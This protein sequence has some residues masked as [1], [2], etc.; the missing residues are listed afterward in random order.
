MIPDFQLIM[1]PLLESLKNG[2]EYDIK[3]IHDVLGKHFE[4]TDN[5]LDELLPD[6]EQTRFY[7]N[8]SH[9]KRHLMVAGLIEHITEDRFKITSLGKQVLCR[10]LNIIDTDYLRRLPG[11]I[12]SI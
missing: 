9:A 2:D 8:L 4:L 5:E 7:N 10:Q 12:E 6:L 3:Q 1:L 11:Y